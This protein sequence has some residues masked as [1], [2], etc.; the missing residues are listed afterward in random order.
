MKMSSHALNMGA[1]LGQIRCPIM[2]TYGAPSIMFVRGQG[3][4]LWDS[5]GARYLDFVGGLAVQSLGHANPE[6]AEAISEQAMKLTQVSNYWAT[7]HAHHVAL[8]LDRHIT[9]AGSSL[10]SEPEF[11]SGQ[12]FFCNSG[13]EANE[14]AFKLARKSTGSGQFEIL[15]AMGSFHGRTLAALAAC[16]QPHKHEPFEPMPSGFYHFQ[17]DEPNSLEA[18]VTSSTAAIHV[19]PIQGEG[20]V[21]PSNK[22]FMSR[23]QELSLDNNVLFMVDEVQSGLCRT[24]K[25]FAFQ[26]FGVKPDVVCIA[27]ALGNGFPIAAVWARAEVASAFQA[28]DHGSTY[29]GNPLGTAA[30]RKVL[31]IMARDNYPQ[32]ASAL[33][34][35]LSDALADLPRVVSVRGMGGMLAAELDGEISAKVALQATENGLLVNPI[36]PTAIRLTPPL[37]TSLDHVDEAMS[38]LKGVLH[39]QAPS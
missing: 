10:S 24:G 33:G 35:V 26:H 23:V 27:K 19:E 29:G 8:E 36:T 21:W 2:P 30:A 34:S 11:P 16:G 38:I 37:S 4:E 17:R 9:G 7:E 22:P 14:L 5:Q 25:W 20:G 39:A 1:E 18:L 28:G 12:V 13:A 31:E 32:K 3:T 6:V 15:T